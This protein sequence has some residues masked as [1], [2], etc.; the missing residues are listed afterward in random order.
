M[1]KA[2]VKERATAIGGE[3]PT[4][5]AKPIIE[6]D[7]PYRA[8]VE[9]QGVAPILFHRWNCEAVEEKAKAAKGSKAKKTDNIESYVY[10]NSDGE[11]CIPGEYLRRACVETGR[12]MQDPR[13]P[14]KSAKDLFNAVIFSLTELASLGTADWDYEDK[15]RVVVQRNAITRVRPAMKEGWKAEFPAEPP[16][17]ADAFEAMLAGGGNGAN[18]NAEADDAINAFCVK[19][20]EAANWAREQAKGFSSWKR[21]S[22]TDMSFEEALET[23]Y[24]AKS[25]YRMN[26]V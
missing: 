3:A 15:R 17:D 22:G 21:T 13:S 1:A 14:R 4:N 12:S 6:I 24:R 7:V 23:A 19:H 25:M 2:S 10:R 9:V 5:G 16:A 18:M 26:K 8:I 11:I 20:P